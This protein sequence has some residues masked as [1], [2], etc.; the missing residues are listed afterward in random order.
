MMRGFASNT[1]HN[2]VVIG[3]C[4]LIFMIL[5]GIYLSHR[6]DVRESKIKYPIITQELQP[7]TINGKHVYKIGWQKDKYTY[8][9]MNVIADSAVV[10]TSHDVRV[11]KNSVMHVSDIEL[12]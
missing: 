3:I 9:E 5:T 6:D 11:S 1:E 7:I 10:Q 8:D 4:T 2:I 12:K